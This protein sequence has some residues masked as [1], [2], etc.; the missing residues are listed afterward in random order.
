MAQTHFWYSRDQFRQVFSVVRFD[1]EKVLVYSGVG[2]DKFSVV[3]FNS[4]RVLVYSVV[5]LVRFSVH[6]E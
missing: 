3:R 4:D 5:G 2:L 6:H 1:L